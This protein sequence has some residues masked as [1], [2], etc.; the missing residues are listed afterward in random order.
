MKLARYKLSEA[1]IRSLDKPGIYG[2]GDGLWIRVQ[3]GGS[4]NWVFVWK[5]SGKRNEI[6]L[7]GYGRGTALVSLKHAREKADEV[8]ERLAR[9]E[10]P[11]GTKCKVNVITFKK[12]MKDLLASKASEW[13]NEKHRDQWHMTLEEY[14]KPLHDMPVAEIAMGDVK[15]VLLEHWKERQISA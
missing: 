8:R 1:R 10:D 14:A 15:D 6:G 5:R 12:C 7:G 11:R 2:D 4:R 13:R 3:K 9:G